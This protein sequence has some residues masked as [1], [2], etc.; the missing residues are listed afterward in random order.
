[1]PMESPSSKSID[2]EWSDG[3]VESYVLADSPQMR[4]MVAISDHYHDDKAKQFAIQA[5]LWAL[6]GI[7]HHVTIRE[8]ERGEDVHF[9]VYAAA[10]DVRLNKQGK[11][12]CEGLLQ[13]CE[14]NC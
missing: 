3:N 5:R 7:L 1:M 2:V 14:A 6:C 4:G 11:V 9:A 10:A 8:W 12:P 13:A